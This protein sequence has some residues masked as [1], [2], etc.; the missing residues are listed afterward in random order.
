MNITVIGVAGPSGSGKTTIA[1]EIHEHYGSER[2]VTISSDNYYK[3]LSHLSAA[4]REKINFDHPDSIDFE[5]L[6]Q[7]LMLLKQEQMVE[8]PMYDFTTHSRT[9]QTLTISPKSIIIVEGILV[10]HP[11][12]L[13]RLYDT[14]I[15][16]HTDSDICF[17]RRLERDIS[18]RARTTENVIAQYKRDVKPMYDQFVAPCEA[19]ADIVIENSDDHFA[20]H[21]GVRFDIAPVVACLS[22]ESTVNRF[23]LFSKVPNSSFCPDRFLS[24]CP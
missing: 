8:I 15:F 20:T 19:R 6:G 23:K 5:L 13:V 16:V 9:Q 4:E 1:N 22:G 11:E 7:H 18:E 12:F 10:L 17:I 3:D 21:D 2:C 14:K 24:A